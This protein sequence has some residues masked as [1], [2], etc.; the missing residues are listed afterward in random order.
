MSDGVLV[1]TLTEIAAMAPKGSTGWWI[2]GSGAL[3]L[4]GIT[5][6][7]IRDVDIL[8]GKDTAIAFL[9][10][11]DL[12]LPAPKPDPFFRSEPFA[13]IL[14]PGLLPIDLAGDMHLFENGNWSPVRPATR[15][16]VA[17]GSTRVFIPSL[18]DQLNI[19]R[20]FGR[21]KD[22][23]RAAMIEAILD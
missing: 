19:L 7:P 16:A 3:V 15:I 10:N 21:P 4:G 2:I 18:S 5:G 6:L 23:E 8:A 14:R 13:Q 17:V 9:A 1:D 12:P 11:W 20:R 22:I